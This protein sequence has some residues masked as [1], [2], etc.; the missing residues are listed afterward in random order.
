MKAP[1]R[2]AVSVLLLVG[3]AFLSAA[4]P[5]N[6]FAEI[7][8]RVEG[9]QESEVIKTPWN[10]NGDKGGYGKKLRAGKRLAKPQNLLVMASQSR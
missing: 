7:I 1:W 10:R 2:L 3:G 6:G 8:G 5:R 9:W 4:E